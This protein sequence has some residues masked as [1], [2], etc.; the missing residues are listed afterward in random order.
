M[1]LVYSKIID[2]DF[3]G[4]F[5]RREYRDLRNK[6][7]ANDVISKLED[8]ILW[9]K[10]KMTDLTEDQKKSDKEGFKIFLRKNKKNPQIESLTFEHTTHD[11][12][13]GHQL[14]NRRQLI[15][16]F[17]S[18]RDKDSVDDI[19]DEIVRRIDLEN[20]ALKPNKEYQECLNEFYNY[21][22][23]IAKFQIQR[24]NIKCQEK[25]ED[26]IQF[27]LRKCF[28]HIDGYDPKKDSST[29]TFFWKQID[30]S[31][32]YYNRK[33]A[34]R[35]TK[36]K[37][38]DIENV[39]SLSD[40]NSEIGE[41]EEKNFYSLCRT[42]GVHV[43]YDEI[44][45]LKDICEEYYFSKG[46]RLIEKD[47]INKKSKKEAAKRGEILQKTKRIKEIEDEEEKAKAK[48]QNKTI[49]A[50]NKKIL[51][52]IATEVT[53]KYGYNKLTDEDKK[54]RY[55]HKSYNKK[56]TKKAVNAYFK[57][58]GSSFIQNFDVLKPMISNYLKK[59]R[60]RVNG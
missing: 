14:E 3:K 1:N 15:S 17:L 52:R 9:G 27:V 11:Q 22:Y 12:L 13:T 45:F 32:K 30:L 44:I 21:C 54:V 10:S 37:T 2:S 31:L 56:N 53:K 7:S 29:Y 28:D 24:K 23:K 60:R 38:V 43:P 50:S 41:I 5:L 26:M 4:I 55:R 59:K 39:R 34:K 16:L 33:E 18:V 19:R 51:E 58:H 42:K 35:N 46:F 57:I 47:E 48:E 8:K 36:I 6:K 25:R 40:E 49:R 20:L